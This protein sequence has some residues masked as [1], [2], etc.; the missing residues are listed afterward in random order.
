MII[1]N[2][3]K[4]LD[5]DQANDLISQG[6]LIRGEHPS[7]ELFIYNYSQKAVYEG[8]WNDITLQ[9]R[10]LITDREGN[11]VGRPFPKFFNLQE[12]QGRNLILPLG[13]FDVYEKLDGSLGILYF[14]KG[15]PYIATRGSFVSEQAQ[16]ATEMLQSNLKAVDIPF[17][18]SGLTYLFEIIYPENRIVVNYGQE[19]SLTFL[20]AIDTETGEEISHNEI[21]SDWYGD[22][23]F[24][25][26]KKYDGIK[27]I[28]EITNL[29][30]PNKEGFVIRFQNGLRIKFKFKDYVKLHAI[31][32]KITK[33]KIWE[34]IRDNKSFDE[35]LGNIPD[36][37]YEWI[38]KTET[39]FREEYRTIEE[40]S[41]LALKQI[42]AP[43][44]KEIALSIVN[45]PMCHVMFS[46][47]DNKD[48]T[49]VIWKSLEPE[50]EIPQIEGFQ[51]HDNDE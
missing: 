50:H 17:L 33:K 49:N 11:I 4:K 46:M 31:V 23:G 20:A 42:L 22:L 13:Q 5:I 30:M 24:P 1:Q 27:D 12:Y 18:D 25:F 15:N 14:H 40:E 7:G 8:F 21:R 32:T 36:E 19:R 9:C 41:K 3:I 28:E 35:F 26:V 45:H 48:H 43:Y 10:G 2:I 51:F 47:L 29:N 39:S 37:L 34:V 44:R 38:K 6:Y 16:V